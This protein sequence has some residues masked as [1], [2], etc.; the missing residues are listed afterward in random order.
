MKLPHIIALAGGISF[1]HLLVIFLVMNG[2]CASKVEKEPEKP[3][4][5]PPALPAKSF[6]GKGKYP[7]AEY[8]DV[9]PVVPGNWKK[10]PEA[11]IIPAEKKKSQ[12]SSSGEKFPSLPSLDELTGMEEFSGKENSTFAFGTLPPPAAPK[13]I[14]KRGDY[15][16]K[17]CVREK[18]SAIPELSRASSGILLH[19]NSRKILWAKN[20]RKKVPIASMTK[21]MT[22]LLACE[23]VENGRVTL[24]T[25]IPATRGAISLREGVVWMRNGESFTL[26]SLME[27]A[28]IKSANDASFL[29][30]EYLGNGKSNDFIQ[31]MNRTARYLKMPSTKFYNPHGLPG[32]KLTPDNTSTVEDLLKLCEYAMTSPL[33]RELVSMRQASFREKGDKGHLTMWNHNHLLPG[34]KYGVKGVKGIKTGYTKNA[35]FC[36]AVSCERDGEEYIGIVTGFPTAAERDRSMRSL[37]QW[38]FI[39]AKNPALP[40]ERIVLQSHVKKNSHIK[41]KTA[42]KK[43]IKRKKTAQQR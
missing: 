39:R 20:P 19:V 12:K 28:A 31:R 29:I 43:G 25:R 13:S 17:N 9:T 21:I 34:G 22:L 14:L 23:D 3:H 36:V 27:A 8:D 1:I 33:F 24:S 38:G 2:G 30:G 32:R 16:Y 26:Q 4:L 41:K 10:K 5:T 40:E 35:G 6:K 11:K 42:G 18:I 37:L 15:N 7:P